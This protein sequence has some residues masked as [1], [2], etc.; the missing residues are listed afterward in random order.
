MLNLCSNDDQL[1]VVL[2]HEMA[3]AILGH[4][5]E[6]LSHAAFFDILL[7][8]ILGLIWALIPS[9][10]F[11]ALIH[12]SF[13]KLMQVTLELPYNRKLETEADEI[14]LTLASKA[15]FDVRESVVFWKKMAFLELLELDLP[16][17]IEMPKEI[18]FLLTHPS[19]ESRAKNLDSLLPDA[20][21]LRDSCNCPRLPLKDPRV[22]LEQK[23]QMMEK[24][25]AF[26]KN[27]IQIKLPRPI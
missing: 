17:G 9:D 10:L 25:K 7:M 6:I 3:H 20:I 19:H 13:N 23:I 14:G 21:K 2:S 11:A 18:E 16:P 12:I 5:A 15:C 8:I 1:G 27:V 24:Q 22:I 4:S 26:D